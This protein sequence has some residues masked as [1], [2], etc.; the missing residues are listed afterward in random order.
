MVKRGETDAR[1]L[2]WARRLLWASVCVDTTSFSPL[3]SS[4]GPAVSH[5]LLRAHERDRWCAGRDAKHLL[6]FRA[7]GLWL[8]Q[9]NKS[10]MHVCHEDV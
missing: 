2:Q 10:K 8:R 7:L 4:D 6:C 9:F 3:I 1:R 5:P